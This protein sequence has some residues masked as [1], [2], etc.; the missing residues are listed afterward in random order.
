MDDQLNDIV[1]RET[2]TTK[3]ILTLLADMGQTFAATQDIEAS[4]QYAVE[5]IAKYV[6]AEAGSLFMLDDD[7]TH[8]YCHACYG[9]VDI[10]GV[11]IGADQGIVGHC[12][13]NIATEIVRDVTNDTRFHQGV[14]D[15]SGFVTRSI[16][17]APLS[18]KGN[19]IG[20]IELINKSS[21]DGLFDTSDLTL[22]STLASS[23]ALAIVNAR[24]AEKLVEQ[25]RVA[26]ELELAAEIQR[27][28]LPSGNEGLPVWGSNIP[29]RTV[30]G[31]FFDYF[32]LEDGR[33]VFNLGDVSGKGMNAA[34]LMAKTS[35]LFR[36]LSKTIEHPG[37]LLGRINT[38]ICETSTRGMFV[39]MVGGIFDPTTG[40]LR[41][42]NAGHEPPLVRDVQG[43][44]R[45]IAAEAPP[46]GIV[47]DFSWENGFPVTTIDLDGGAFYLFTDGVTEGYVEDGVELGVDG[48]QKIIDESSTESI[49]LQ[50]ERIVASV[51]GSGIALRDDLTVLG[52]ADDL[53]KRPVSEDN[54]P[55]V[56]EKAVGDA[57][58]R[59]QF[60][61]LT[62]NSSP[63]RLRMI[64]SMV[65]DGA[66][67]LGFSN[68]V[69]Q[70]L[71][72]AVD[73]ACQN[74]I[75]YAYGG[76]HDGTMEIVLF[77][78]EDNLIIEVRDQA[79]HVDPATIK[80]RDL[81]DVRPGGLGTHLMNQVM[82]SVEYLPLSEEG[83]NILRMIKIIS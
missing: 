81:D 61:S 4:L 67:S 38:E 48:V 21:G 66:K 55:T 44:Y 68:E 63:E 24:M 73:E 1:T 69:I 46:L 76:K 57:S 35:S 72:L 27:S 70:D 36:C 2:E 79:P 54:D 15:E 30:S 34:L 23:A 41:I 77:S 45:A 11:E 17:C 10:V 59:Q 39:T 13:Q 53:L 5:H 80:P 47:D 83:G 82:N 43:N 9:D 49:N 62:T 64:R 20:A 52:I 28:L 56:G 16:L 18:V 65:T 19:C 40:R 60:A 8:L 51:F 7:E 31:D 6:G 14:D 32:E 42:A 29:A 37:R 58:H 33:I 71:I 25:E 22:L 50:L 12:V 75:R 3:D 74:V 26:R 78:D